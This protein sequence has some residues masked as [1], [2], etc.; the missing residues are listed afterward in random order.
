KDGQAR[1]FTFELGVKSVITGPS[2]GAAK[3]QRGLQT[4]TGVAWSGAGKISK[5]EVSADGGGSWAECVLHGASLPK[6]MTRFSIAWDWDGRPSILMSRATDETGAVQPTRAVWYEP[7]AAG[8]LYHQNSIH[9][10]AVDQN[11]EVSNVYA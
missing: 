5:V 1:K 9:S 11:G 10:W 6:A 8:Q 3:V 4:I 2:Y 7:Y